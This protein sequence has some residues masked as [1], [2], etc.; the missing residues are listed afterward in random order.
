LK[1]YWHDD[2]LALYLGDMAEIVPALE[3]DLDD[4]FAFDC[5]ITD[6]PYGETH[7][8][9][10]T[11]PAG[12]PDVVGGVTSSLWCFGTMRMFTGWWAE[13]DG[14]AMS[15]DCVWRKTWPNGGEAAPVGFVTDRFRRAHELILHF[16]RGPWAGVHHE[17]PREQLAGWR[18]DMHSKRRAEP[19]ANWY[20]KRDVSDWHENGTRIRA[21]VLDAPS[22]RKRNIA[23]TQKPVAILAPLIEYSCPPG[24]IVL[25]PFAGSGSTL[26][27]CRATGRRCVGIEADEKQLEATVLRLAQLAMD[28]DAPLLAA[29]EAG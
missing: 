7:F 1:P 16:Y 27:A 29:E 19:D 24:G 2:T 22:V 13:F 9:W 11:W 18:P 25:D 26:D 8:R 4:G 21:S 28:F 20:G 5:A 15:Q 10:D 17:T 23:P 14:W 6:P 12:W 3:F